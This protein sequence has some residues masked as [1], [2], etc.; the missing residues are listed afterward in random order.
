[1]PFLEV[2]N[3][4]QILETGQKYKEEIMKLKNQLVGQAHLGTYQG[5][6][7]IEE[8]E[9]DHP[10]INL[11]K[12]SGEG[13]DGGEGDRPASAMYGQSKLSQLF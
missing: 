12:G 5:D 7:F 3:R 6:R 13:S 9:H 2:C 10:E 4:E 8:A 11:A 1:V